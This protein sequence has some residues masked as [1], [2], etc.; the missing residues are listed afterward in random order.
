[1]VGDPNQLPPTVISR[2]AANSNY[3]KSLFS[4]LVT[5]NSPY[6]LNIQ[7]RMHPEISKFP[8]ERFYGSRLKNGPSMDAVNHQPWFKERIFKPYI[9]F[10]VV[11]SIESKSITKSLSNTV[12]AKFVVNLVNT[13]LQR[14]SI[15]HGGKANA[16]KQKTSFKNQIC[17]V[18][19]YKEQIQLIRSLFIKKFGSTILE[20]V[21]VE[22]V[23]S[24]Q[25]QE[26]TIIIFSC[27]RSSSKS[28]SIGFLRD[29]RK[30][31]VALTRGKSN[32][33]IVGNDNM[34]IND[35]LWGS[36]I[37]DAE[38]R[39]CKM[40]KAFFEKIKNTNEEE[41][42][43]IDNKFLSINSNNKETIEPINKKQVDDSKNLQSYKG[44]CVDEGIEYEDDG[45]GLTSKFKDLD[46]Q[47]S[48][49]T[50]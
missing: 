1:M 34:L 50:K 44:R 29:F 4:R 24:F 27:V 49:V 45:C 41:A 16:S 36:L 31:N 26:K 28:T 23:D 20:T 22:T 19:P 14:Y 47:K 38:Q 40:T 25:G 13:L 5:V 2:V 8:S 6:L 39:G 9:F 21:S 43:N 30:L 42:K 11:D 37:R 35:K 10:S 17:I 15:G 7:Y 46:I 3:N 32:M 12:E 48:V 33:W 18:S